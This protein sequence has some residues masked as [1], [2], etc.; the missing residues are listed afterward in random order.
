MIRAAG[1]GQASPYLRLPGAGPIAGAGSPGVELFSRV[2]S[3]GGEKIRPARAPKGPGR[4]FSSERS[5]SPAHN[6]SGM[7]EQNAR[8]EG[9]FFFFLATFLAAAFFFFAIVMAPYDE[10]PNTE[11]TADP[12]GTL[13]KGPDDVLFWTAS[14]TREPLPG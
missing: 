9:Y 6:G 1:R 13:K 11:P 4:P 8:E 3:P 10:C 5:R 14:H 7:P 2:C 12:S